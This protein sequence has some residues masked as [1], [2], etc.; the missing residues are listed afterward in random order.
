MYEVYFYYKDNGVTS[1]YYKSSFLTKKAANDH[2]VEKKAELIETGKI[3][4]EIKKTFGQVYEEFLDVGASQYQES[5]IHNTK[6]YYRYL[7]KELSHIPI[8]MFDYSLLQKFFNSKKTNGYATNE[9]MKKTIN[10]VLNYA[11]K[12]DYIKTN[13]LSLVTITGVENHI[14]RDEVLLY[15][16]F[17]ALTEE[18][19]RNGSFRYKAYSMAIKIGYYTGLRVSEI[20]AL[21]KSDFNFEDNI[22]NV[23]KKLVY[24]G[25]RKEEIHV[26]NQMKSR[27]SKAV[28][29]LAKPLKEE[30]IRWF[31]E[32]PFERVL[33]DENEYY[34]NPHVISIAIKKKASL[35]GINFHFHMLRHTFATTLV[36]NNV[37]L[38]TAQE[39]MRHTNLDTTI[40]VYTHINE[41]HKLDVVNEIFTKK[42]GGKVANLE[43]KKILN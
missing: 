32:N 11:I 5:T 12:V 23:N 24:C 31:N 34:F 28:I 6:K 20:L 17:I 18:L 36:T 40:S 16:D 14:E 27:K 39:L 19:E 7:E 9:G 13:P 1:R 21:E 43:N 10:R 38:K 22:I 8:T 35:L 30:L 4:K 41:Q 2:E 42:S 3:R 37:D 33:C 25:L 26:T 29:P 15:D